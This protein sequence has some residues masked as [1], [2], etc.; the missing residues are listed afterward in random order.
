MRGD[1]FLRL[2]SMIEAVFST[3][4]Q[5]ALYIDQVFVIHRREHTSD[6]MNENFDRRS[7]DTLY[8]INFSFNFIF[9]KH[10]N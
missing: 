3:A 2:S 5:S 10:G 9:L 7:I 8:V 6:K 1:V 4:N